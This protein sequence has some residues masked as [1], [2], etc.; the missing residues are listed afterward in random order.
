MTSFIEQNMMNF[1][2]ARDFVLHNQDV[3]R[4]SNGAA[5]NEE[6]QYQ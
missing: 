5:I 1:A 3:T 2:G 6:N 4:K